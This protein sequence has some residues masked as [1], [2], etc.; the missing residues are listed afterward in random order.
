MKQVLDLAKDLPEG[1]IFHNF[2]GT[3]KEELDKLTPLQRD[4]LIALVATNMIG[5]TLDVLTIGQP[6]SLYRPSG[7]NEIARYNPSVL[8]ITPNNVI[9]A[10]SYEENREGLTT[11]IRDTE[12]FIGRQAFSRFDGL[13][14]D[15]NGRRTLM[16]GVLSAHQL[17]AMQND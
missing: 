11:I 4:F 9:V 1:I 7:R 2:L 13:S 6:V 3:H 15:N 5:R 12:L 14:L 17:P 8:E 16:G 10:D